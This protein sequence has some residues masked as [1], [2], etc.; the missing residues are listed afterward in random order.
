MIRYFAYGSN[1][2]PDQMRRHVPDARA[3]G[4]AKL[5]GHRLAFSLYSTGWGGGVANLEPDPRAHTWGVLWEM[6]DEGIEA[7][8][9]YEGHPTFYRR[10]ELDVNG[11]AGRVTAWTYRV[12]H[13]RAYVRPTDEYLQAITAGIRLQGLPPEAF[14]L[15]DEATRPSGPSISI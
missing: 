6:P 15:L 1:I 11:P 9:A 10:E 8:D 14:D 4:P 7:L 3:V 5:E 13:Q 12:A 2:H